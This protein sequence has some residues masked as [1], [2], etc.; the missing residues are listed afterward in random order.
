M[1]ILPFLREFLLILNDIYSL[2]LE[3]INQ[4]KILIEQKHLLKAVS[5]FSSLKITLSEDYNPI[6]FEST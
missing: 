1:H 2:Y 4:I 5:N 3:N 6:V